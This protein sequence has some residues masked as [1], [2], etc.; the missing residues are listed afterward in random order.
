MAATVR[1]ITLGRYS[2]SVDAKDDEVTLLDNKKI[3]LGN[4]NDLEI[5]H[6]GTHSFIDEKGT[7]NLYL[8]SADE[9]QLRR[10]AT[11]EKFIRCIGDSSVE[12]YH[13]GQKT[14]ETVEGGIK[15]TGPSKGVCTNNLV[16]NGNCVVAQRGT[17]SSTADSIVVDRFYLESQNNDET[18]THAQVDV[19][20]GTT[21][22]ELGFRKAW[23]VTNGNQTS[24]AGVDDRIQL[25]LRLEA[26][27][28]ANS[29]W[30][31]TSTSSYITLQFWIKSSVA[32]NFYG[33]VKTADGTQQNY[34]FE[35]GSLTADTW[36]KVTKTIPGNSNITVD[37]D[38]GEGLR[39]VWSM[40]KGTNKTDSGVALN[41][42]AA[43]GSGTEMPDNTSTWYTTDDATLE[44]T[45]VQLEL[46]QTANDFKF[47]SYAETLSK[48]QRYYQ[49]WGGSGTGGDYGIN[50]GYAYDNGNKTATGLNLSTPL[51]TE[52]TVEN[53]AAGGHIYSQGAN[54]AISSVLGVA[55]TENSNWVA[56]A[57]ANTSDLG[58]ADYAA[59]LTN[60]TNQHIGLDAEL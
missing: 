26:R 24:G 52:P 40:F 47:E 31:Y 25:Q 51:R 54:S 49:R 11:N 14:F 5:Y 53:M 35:T 28:I 19:S 17:T 23:K 21:P 20:S 15:I 9:L 43:H 10:Y 6:N 39:I 48:C 46:G 56:L 37:N 30:H 34:P 2:D 12:I 57:L 50:G 44:L 33:Y 60:N 27:N 41:T 59:A 8:S 38:N 58:N 55:Y 16:I 32:Q 36:T 4:S 45:G 18:P 7:G 29:G 42:W 1:P 3:Y 13:N 22:Y